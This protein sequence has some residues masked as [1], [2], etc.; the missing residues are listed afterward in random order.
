MHEV[1]DLEKTSSKRSDIMGHIK[2]IFILIQ[3]ILAGTGK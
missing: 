1:R 2:E 3:S